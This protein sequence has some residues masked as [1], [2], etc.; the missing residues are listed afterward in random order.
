[1]KIFTA[2]SP[3]STRK[4]TLQPDEVDVV[5]ETNQK[6]NSNTLAEAVE[7]INDLDISNEM[8]FATR[9]VRSLPET[10]TNKA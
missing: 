3:F 7:A 1:M 9:P 10:R 5:E 6:E 4:E 8:E 2:N